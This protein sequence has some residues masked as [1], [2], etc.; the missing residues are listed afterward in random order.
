ML[1]ALTSLALVGL[2]IHTKRIYMNAMKE[3][4]SEQ[5]ALPRP[6]GRVEARRDPSPSQP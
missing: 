1:V 3:M 2:A 5:Q 6:R 4:L